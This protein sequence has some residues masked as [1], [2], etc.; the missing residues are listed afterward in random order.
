M[1]SASSEVN[2]QFHPPPC[3]F[4]YGHSFRGYA[5]AAPSYE[6]QTITMIGFF[7]LARLS[8]TA[9][10]TGG[11]LLLCWLPAMTLAAPPDGV[12][13]YRVAQR[14]PYDQPGQSPPYLTSPPQQPTQG[15]FE[16]RA[17]LYFLA[18]YAVL[19]T[20][21]GVGF[22]V[23]LLLILELLGGAILALVLATVLLCYATS[24]MYEWTLGLRRPLGRWL[25]RVF[26]VIWLGLLFA[27]VL[28]GFS[29]GVGFYVALTGFILPPI[30]IWL[31]LQVGKALQ[32]I[33]R[34]K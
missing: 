21:G 19:L 16:G 10:W 17:W 9:W 6:P 34:K 32:E 20:S 27:M 5:R 2:N 31:V 28:A 26:H 18:V 25:S 22:V 24:L 7:S 29:S 1:V 33:G 11:L 8:R 13:A 14:A 30:L 23:T 3:V 4:C 12:P 15:K